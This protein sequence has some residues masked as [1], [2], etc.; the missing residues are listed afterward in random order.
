MRSNTKIRPFLGTDQFGGKS[1]LSAPLIQGPRVRD[2]IRQK[3]LHDSTEIDVK[4]SIVRQD[5]TKSRQG[6][7]DEKHT[8][9]KETRK[10]LIETWKNKT[11]TSPYTIN[12]YD[13]CQDILH[14]QKALEEKRKQLQKQE[15]LLGELDGIPKNE[16]FHTA[17]SRHI[18]DTEL[19]MA[20]KYRHLDQTRKK[21]EHEQSILSTFIDDECAV[22]EKSFVILQND[23]T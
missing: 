21:L 5:L 1:P 22:A 9:V 16:V 23:K 10:V 3:V 20:L 11:T 14:K 13:R 2:E 4:N 15:K 12:Q 18:L 19:K 17:L 7:E 8:K 6:R